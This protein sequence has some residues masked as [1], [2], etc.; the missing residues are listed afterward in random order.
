MAAKSFQFFSDIIFEKSFLE[1]L[2]KNKY[3]DFDSKSEADQKQLKIALLKDLL[4][5]DQSELENVQNNSDNFRVQTKDFEIAMMKKLSALKR[6]VDVKNY[7]L[8]Q[9]SFK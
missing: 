6:K 8:R 4:R 9:L 3:D 5:R 2:V 7:I 1:R